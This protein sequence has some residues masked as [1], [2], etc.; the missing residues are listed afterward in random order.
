[1]HDAFHAAIARDRVQDL[2]QTT[3]AERT[4]RRGSR[5]ATA[6]DTPPA[7]GWAWRVIEVLRLR[8]GLR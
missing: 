6:E 1:M 8:P 3:A 4:M 7:T 5:F 2:M